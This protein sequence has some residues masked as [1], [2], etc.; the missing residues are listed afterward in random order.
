MDPIHRARIGDVEFFKKVELDV[1]KTIDD[2]GYSPL[3]HAICSNQFE[4]VKVIYKRCPSLLSNQSYKDCYTDLHHAAS[5]DMPHIVK[6]LIHS[7]AHHHHVHQ[8]DLDIECGQVGTITKKKKKLL[9]MLDTERYTALHRAVINKQFQTVKLL[10]QAD[11][12]FIHPAATSGDTP[13]MTAMTGACSSEKMFKLLLEMQPSQSK[14]RMG[15]KGWT[16]LHYAASTGNLSSVENIIRFCPDCS[17]VLDNEGQNFLHV[18]AM[19]KHVK[20]IK[21]ILG[22]KEIHSSVLNG[23]DNKG[24]T[25]LHVAALS[26]NESMT[27]CLLADPRVDK[28]LSVSTHLHWAVKKQNMEIL[29]LLIEADPDFFKG[30]ELNLLLTSTD[31]NGDSI[32]SKAAQENYLYW[33]EEIYK[34]CPSLL[35]HQSK[36]GHTALH[37]AAWRGEPEMVKFFISV[38]AKDIKPI[39]T[40]YTVDAN[41]ETALHRAVFNHK[42]EAVRLLIEADPHFEYGAN[43]SGETPLLMAIREAQAHENRFDTGQIQRLIVKMQPSQ[44]KVRTGDNRWTSLHYATYK[45][46]LS[47]IEDIIQFCPDCLELVDNEGMN[48][49]HLAA[50][51][52][53]IQL[54]KHFVGAKE[55]PANVFNRKDNYGNTPLHIAALSGNESITICLLYD[56]RVDKNTVNNKGQHVLHAIHFDYDKRKAGIHRVGDR[57]DQKDLKDQSDFD[58]VVGALIATVSFTAGITVPGGYIS[59]GSNRGTAVLAKTLSFEAFV[60]SNTLALLFSLYA[61]FSHFCTR[62][63]LKMEDIIYQLNVA[64]FCTL[65]AIYAMLVAFISGSFA[66]LADSSRLAII[67]C[68]LCCCFFM[69]ACRPIWKIVMQK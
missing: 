16:A 68:V 21:Y 8:V 13:L 48:F 19:G 43:S 41:G 57:L 24:K 63:L 52:E 31:E 12:D 28:M 59:D 2:L 25:P 51:L 5:R 9:R 44:I 58:L 54:V 66:V 65:G 38:D 35:Y 55:I 18:V 46:Y 62:R 34:R 27:L 11:P 26:E 56:P 50:K 23:E 53:H 69:F 37:H 32:L 47:A 40:L 1:L 17:E 33:C 3:S 49:L 60:I 45:G 67:V 39:K 36:H 6:F 7:E 15:N 42:L 22:T 10:I 61:V 4:C 64:T 29:K 20:L 30:V 14:I